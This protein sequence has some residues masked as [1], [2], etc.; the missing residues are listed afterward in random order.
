MRDGTQVILVHT[1][2]ACPERGGAMATQART[3]PRTRRR[4]RT[5]APPLGPSQRRGTHGGTRTERVSVSLRCKP[6]GSSMDDC[7][8]FK[9]E[10]HGPFKTDAR[11]K[12]A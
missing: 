2:D 3:P 8:S 4:A 9:T 12:E 6:D 5:A 11:R 7:H 1:P 10:A